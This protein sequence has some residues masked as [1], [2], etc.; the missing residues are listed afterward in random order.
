MAWPTAQPVGE[1]PQGRD[2]VR[3]EHASHRIP[4]NLGQLFGPALD[5]RILRSIFINGFRDLTKPSLHLI[6]GFVCSNP[7][8]KLRLKFVRVLSAAEQAGSAKALH[9]SPSPRDT[10]CL[11]FKRS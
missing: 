8:A 1:H 4:K 10:F 9:T 7:G 6:P 3:Q 5:S 11:G 2:V